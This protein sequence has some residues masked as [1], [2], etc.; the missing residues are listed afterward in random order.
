MGLRSGKPPSEQLAPQIDAGAHEGNGRVVEPPMHLG[1]IEIGAQTKTAPREDEAPHRIQMT[2]AEA[3]EHAGAGL[4]AH[5]TQPPEAGARPER[6]P[7]EQVETEA[8]AV[9]HPA[10][11]V[12]QKEANG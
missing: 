5:V 12:A 9:R 4:N 3:S 11:D 8:E 2:P 10:R 6:R 1:V 7:L